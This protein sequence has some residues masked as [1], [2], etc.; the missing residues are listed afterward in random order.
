MTRKRHLIKGRKE[1]GQFVALPHSVLKHP[2]YA[3]LSFNARALLVE[4]MLE[5]NGVNNGDLNAAW[6]RLSQRGWRSKTTLQKAL[7]ELLD[8]EF[9]VKTRHGWFQN[10]G[11]RCNLYAVTWKHVDECPKKNLEIGPTRIPLRAFSLRP[12]KS[13]SP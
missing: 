6:S 5:F 9:I 2:D 4:F 12:P 8:L 10:P 11:S 1:S 3:K 7:N 13:Q